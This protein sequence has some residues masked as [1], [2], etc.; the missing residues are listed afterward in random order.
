MRR[1]VGAGMTAYPEF[2]CAPVLTKSLLHVPAS[3]AYLAGE[4]L[5]SLAYRLDRKQSRDREG[6]P[7]TGL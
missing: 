5:G 6:E 3:P 7:A 2:L 4:S 1:E